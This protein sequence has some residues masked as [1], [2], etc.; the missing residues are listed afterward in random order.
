[1]FALDNNYFQHLQIDR[2][3]IGG[4]K[5]SIL[6]YAEE[7]RYIHVCKKMVVDKALSHKKGR[8]Y[9]DLSICLAKNH[10]KW[11]CFSLHS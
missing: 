3:V 1:M 6:S 9:L 5:L 8:E 2:L 4:W 7:Y 11:M 10:P